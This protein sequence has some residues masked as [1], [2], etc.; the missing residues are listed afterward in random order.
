[1]Q[2]INSIYQTES[3][4]W[5][6]IILSLLLLISYSVILRQSLSGVLKSVLYTFNLH[7]FQAKIILTFPKKYWEYGKLPESGIK[8]AFN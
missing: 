6:I 7:H 4:Y 3:L 1:M 8:A 2:C 5:D